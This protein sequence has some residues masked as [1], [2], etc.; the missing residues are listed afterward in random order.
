VKLGLSDLPSYAS[1]ILVPLSLG[2]SDNLEDGVIMGSHVLCYCFNILPLAGSPSCIALGDGVLRFAVK[3]PLGGQLSKGYII[4]YEIT[5]VMG[6]LLGD[7]SS[8]MRFRISSNSQVYYFL[9]FRASL[10]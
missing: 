8:F 1:H 5:D 3:V 6:L 4:L 7:T 2:N 9:L 10:G